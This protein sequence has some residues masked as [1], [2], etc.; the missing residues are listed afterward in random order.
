MIIGLCACKCDS[1]RTAPH[2]WT[3]TAQKQARTKNL[4]QVHAGRTHDVSIYVSPYGQYDALRLKM[5]SMSSLCI[6]ANTALSAELFG[7]MRHI[8]RG[9][10]NQTCKSMQKCSKMGSKSDEKSRKSESRGPKIDENGD[11][12]CLQEVTKRE[13]GKNSGPL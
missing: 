1:T 4:E 9:M 11:R 7:N 6:S 10:Q 8:N 2:A 5:L 13:V 12:G 3:L